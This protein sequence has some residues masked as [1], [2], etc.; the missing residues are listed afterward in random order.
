M[1]E[2]KNINKLKKTEL[3]DIITQYEENKF[4]RLK[5]ELGLPY[6]DEE[7][8]ISYIKKIQNLNAERLTDCNDLLQV[9]E[10]YKHYFANTFH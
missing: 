3:I 6:N 9:V 8:W 2:T 7:E 10:G 5:E 1:V 4:N